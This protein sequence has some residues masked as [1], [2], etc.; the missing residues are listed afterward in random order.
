M[1]EARGRYRIV[2][3]DVDGTLLSSEHRILPDTLEAVRA[4]RQQ[5]IPF[6]IVSARSPSGVYPILEEYGLRCPI[7]CYSG[8]LTLDEDRNILHSTGFSRDTAAEVID[9]L[10]ERGFDCAWNLFCGDRW[11]VKSRRDPRVQR[12]EASVRA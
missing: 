3:S 6:V 4:L 2:F 5:G 11:I 1:C 9:F 12:E 10:E 8:A 7:I